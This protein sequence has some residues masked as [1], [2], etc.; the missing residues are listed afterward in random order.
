MKNFITMTSETLE[1]GIWNL[2]WS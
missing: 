2:V 1:L